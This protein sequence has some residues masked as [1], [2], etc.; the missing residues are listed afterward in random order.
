[1]AATGN[2]VSYVGVG[3]FTVV[4]DLIQRA[5]I[6]GDTQELWRALGRLGRGASRRRA[7]RARAPLP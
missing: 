1:V 7:R 3:L 4:D 5:W 6:V 2:R